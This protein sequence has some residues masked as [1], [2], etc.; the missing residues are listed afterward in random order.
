MQA[1]DEI[2]QRALS[3]IAKAGDLA[4]LEAVRVQYMGKKG[5]LTSLLKNLGELSAT[6]RPKAGFQLNVAKDQITLAIDSHKQ[7]LTA[8]N[9][10]AQLAKDGVDITLSSRGMPYGGLHPVT[11]TRLRIEEAFR[12]LGFT[13][14]E[15]P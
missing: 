12:G 3:D 8:S 7:K 11:K 13:I 4:S 5:E 14:A 6:D 10:D 9:L 1:L 2:V 15:G